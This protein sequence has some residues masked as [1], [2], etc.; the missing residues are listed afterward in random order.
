VIPLEQ[1]ARHARVEEEVSVYKKGGLS[2]SR[3]GKN[4][5]NSTIAERTPLLFQSIL[6]KKPILG[7]ERPVQLERGGGSFLLGKK[8]KKFF[9]LL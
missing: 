9:K 7:G 2:A 5:E 8:K 6:K 3:E 4:C 1:I